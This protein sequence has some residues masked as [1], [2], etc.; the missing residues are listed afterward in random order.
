MILFVTLNKALT[1]P[2]LYASYVNSN[3][4]LYDIN[5]FTISSD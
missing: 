2:S 3:L 1:F 5:T 4:L